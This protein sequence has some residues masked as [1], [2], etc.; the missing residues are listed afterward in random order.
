MARLRKP[1]GKAKYFEFLI[2]TGADYTLISHY[3]A[4]IL[5]LTYKAIKQKEIKV[6]VA[7]L[8]FIHTKKVSLILTIDNHDFK[9]PVLV[10]REKAEPLLGRKRTSH[11]QKKTNVCFQKQF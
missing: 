2:D 9:I 1:N 7:N 10:A 4:Q 8:T 6:E 3:D 11:I 5:G